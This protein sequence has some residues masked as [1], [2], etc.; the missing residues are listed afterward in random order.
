MKNQVFLTC[1]LMRLEGHLSLSKVFFR[2][3]IPIFMKKKF[4]EV[5]YKCNKITFSFIF[6]EGLRFKKFLLRYFRC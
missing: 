6:F 3:N 2:K 1:G 5:L 4:Q